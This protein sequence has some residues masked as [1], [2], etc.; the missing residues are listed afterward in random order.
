MPRTAV[1]PSAPRKVVARMMAGKSRSSSF[2]IMSVAVNSGFTPSEE[3]KENIFG[4][5]R[6]PRS[7][8][9][10]LGQNMIL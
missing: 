10:I 6:E 2:L 4:S 8:R 1:F 3:R 7:V 9:D 5:R